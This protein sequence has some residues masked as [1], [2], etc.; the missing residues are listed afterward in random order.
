LTQEQTPWALGITFAA[1]VAVGFSVLVGVLGYIL[2]ALH[3]IL[4]VGLFGLINA[5]CAAPLRQWG[6][7]IVLR[8]VALGIAVGMAAGWCVVAALI[9]AR[10][11]G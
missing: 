1:L 11:S 3:P 7:R 9:I 8:W 5:G 4:A 2:V 10:A 6:Q